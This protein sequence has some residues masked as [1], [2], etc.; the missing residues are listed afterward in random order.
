M[1]AAAGSSSAAI[2]AKIAS[3]EE[4]VD[5][6][7]ES[8][9]LNQEAVKM[10][11]AKLDTCVQQL[12]TAVNGLANKKVAGG[13]GAK[14]AGSASEKPKPKKPFAPNIGEWFAEMYVT[15][16]SKAM[17]YLSE[18]QVNKFKANSEGN[19]ISAAKGKTGVGLQKTYATWI[20]INIIKADAKLSEKLDAEYKEAKIQHEYSDAPAEPSE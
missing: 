10:Q 6:L 19:K 1:A 16:E 7:V 18:D 3:L 15:N 14:K 12:Q 17:T 5:K 20:Y 8:N 11:L 2:L 9:T 4:K 13:A